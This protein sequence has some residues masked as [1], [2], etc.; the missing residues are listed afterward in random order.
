MKTIKKT[1]QILFTM[2]LLIAIAACGGNT[3]Q[4]QTDADTTQEGQMEQLGKKLDQEKA[5]LEQNINEAVT[6]FNKRMEDYEQR[7]TEAGKTIDTRTDRAMMNLRMKRDTLLLQ[8]EK[9]GEKT[10]ENWKEFKSDMNRQSDEF[11]QAV[12]DFF[13]SN[14]QGD[15]K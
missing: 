5:E 3:N 11:Q 2:T 15:S 4:D 1:L 12:N 7:M 6:T 8:M 14:E 10:Q 13:T 9:A